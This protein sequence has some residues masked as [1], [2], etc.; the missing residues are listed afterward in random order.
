MDLSIH[1]HKMFPLSLN[2]ALRLQLKPFWDPIS[3]IRGLGC[4]HTAEGHLGFFSLTRLE[5]IA[6]VLEFMFYL[7]EYV[8]CVHISLIVA[9]S[10]LSLLF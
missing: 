8:A 5:V 9:L 7:L 2:S 6:M 1:V 4:P 10:F 3:S